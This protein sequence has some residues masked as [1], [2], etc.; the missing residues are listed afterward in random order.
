MKKIMIATVLILMVLPL[1]ATDFRIGPCLG[2]VFTPQAM[3]TSETDSGV[4]TKP[5]GGFNLSLHGLFVFE[6]TDSTFKGGVDFAASFISFPVGGDGDLF[7]RPLEQGGGR[8]GI[9]IVY[10]VIEEDL[11]LALAVG[12]VLIVQEHKAQDGSFNSVISTGPYFDAMAHIIFDNFGLGVGFGGEMLYPIAYHIDDINSP[13]KFGE[14][15]LYA[16]VGVF[17]RF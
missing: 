9:A 16:H 11:E 17:Y 4:Y 14:Y 6:F 7:H 1:S 5:A 13:M 10:P 2:Y 12:S 8:I 15:A 3:P